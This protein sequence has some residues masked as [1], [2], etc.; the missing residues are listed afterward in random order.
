[1][2]TTS[3]SIDL[4][5]GFSFPI[6]RE[7]IHLIMDLPVGGQAIPF[8]STPETVVRVNME[9]WGKESTPTVNELAEII[10]SGL[11]GPAFAKAF[12]L[13]ANCVLLCPN[14][15]C[16]PSSSYYQV[17]SNVEKMKD[18]D[19]CSFV[20]HWLLLSVNKYQLNSFQGNCEG[21][22]LIPVV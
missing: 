14:N 1:M 5:N 12:M 11:S 13:L 16:L 17:I 8:Y 7:S 21:C 4:P 18:F 9:I 6:T 22:G 10:T 15:Q 2:D 3:G 19:W 20:L